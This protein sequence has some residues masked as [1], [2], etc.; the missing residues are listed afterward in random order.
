MVH[1]QVPG[2]EHAIPYTPTMLHTG[3]VAWGSQAGRRR[4]RAQAVVVGL[5][6]LEGCAFAA[7]ARHKRGAATLI[8]TEVL[9]PPARGGVVCGARTAWWGVREGWGRVLGALAQAGCGPGSVVV[10]WRADT[11]QEFAQTNSINK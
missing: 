5:R 11:T 4:A 10:G 1:V 9:R 8:H 3:T 2:I 6:A 7:P